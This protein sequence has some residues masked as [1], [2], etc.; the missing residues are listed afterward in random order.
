[1]ARDKTPI[2]PSN[3]PPS[4]PKPRSRQNML[5][6]LAVVASI[7]GGWTW[8]HAWEAGQ[9]ITQTQVRELS[10][11]VAKA[12]Q[13]QRRSTQAVWA[14]IHA[15]LDVRRAENIKKGDMDKARTLLL[16]RIR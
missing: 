1:M 7:G 5:A 2:Q 11:L 16:A 8:H 4:P 6:I 3:H 9:P 10:A 13:S 12:A 14:D 15:Y